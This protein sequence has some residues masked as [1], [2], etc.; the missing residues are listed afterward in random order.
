[1]SNINKK[2][3]EEINVKAKATNIIITMVA[4]IATTA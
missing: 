2:S 3:T 1:M 4:R